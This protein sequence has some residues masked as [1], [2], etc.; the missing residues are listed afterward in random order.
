[1]SRKGSWARSVYIMAWRLLFR[2]ALQRFF[3]SFS[4]SHAGHQPLQPVF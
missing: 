2:L 1:M 3:D 4:V